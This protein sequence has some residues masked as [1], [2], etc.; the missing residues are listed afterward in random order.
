MISVFRE[1]FSG[2]SKSNIQHSKFEVLRQQNAGS[3]AARN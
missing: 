3:G 1:Q 2:N